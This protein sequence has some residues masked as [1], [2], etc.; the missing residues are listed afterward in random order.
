MNEIDAMHKMTGGRHA[1]ALQFGVTSR[2]RPAKLD[3]TR[4]EEIAAAMAR[5]EVTGESAEAIAERFGVSARYVFKLAKPKRPA[6]PP[7]TV[8][9]PETS[10]RQRIKQLR[11]RKGPGAEIVTDE[12]ERITV[13]QRAKDVLNA[14]YAAL[15]DGWRTLHA[16]REAAKAEITAERAALHAEITAGR[17]ANAKREAE[18][19]DAAKSLAAELNAREAAIQE[20]I[21]RHRVRIAKANG[22]FLPVSWSMPTPRLAYSIACGPRQPKPVKPQRL[23]WEAPT[24]SEAGAELFRAML[25]GQ[26]LPADA[27]ATVRAAVAQLSEFAAVLQPANSATGPPPAEPL[28]PLLP[29]LNF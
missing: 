11:P 15:A 20:F 25:R 23:P 19:N 21:S 22:P 28:P 26:A 3:K 10:L 17:E 27:V 1:V 14:K 18:L 29:D 8:S 6:A 13:T 4:R 12:G 7:V 16:D 5:R 2:G 24:A 9:S